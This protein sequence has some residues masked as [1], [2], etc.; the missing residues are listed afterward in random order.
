LSDAPAN[1]LNGNLRLVCAATPARGTFLAEQ[2]FS[3]PIHLSKSYWNGD[4]LLVHLV[5]PTAGIFG[6]DCL[7]THVAVEAGARVLLSTP[8]AAR[9]HPSRGRESRL[10]QHFEI[11]A[12]G[13]LD[14]YPEISIPQRDSISRQKTT[15]HLEPGAELIFLETLTPGRV[16]S[17]EIFAFASYSWSTDIFVDDRAILRERASVSPGDNSI[18]GLRAIFPAS[19]YASLVLVPANAERFGNDF[20]NEVAQ[21]AT[22]RSLMIA[23]SKLNFHGWSIRLLAANSVCFQEG[24]RKARALIYERLGRKQ[25]DAR[26]NG[27]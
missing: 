8:S 3:A 11:R 23:A 6:G 5:N 12:G 13:S 22:S 25:P 24:I 4:T 1:S 17:G 2:S 14:V 26:R 21:L 19:Y 16:A 9:F 7:R 10:E 20:P 18:A 27:L 15:I